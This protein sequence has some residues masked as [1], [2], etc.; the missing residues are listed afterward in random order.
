MGCTRLFHSSEATR[1]NTRD[2]YCRRCLA[3]ARSHPPPQIHLSTARTS[4]PQPSP[5]IAHSLVGQ[6][7]AATGSRPLAPPGALRTRVVPP[8]RPPRT[9]LPATQ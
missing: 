7:A 5:L 6:Q 1:G 8:D 3:S 4:N 9:W 2:S